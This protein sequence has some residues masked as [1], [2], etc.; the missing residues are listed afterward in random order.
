MNNFD[1]SSSGIDIDLNIF[2]DLSEAHSRWHENFVSVD[3]ENDSTYLFIMDGNLKDTVDYTVLPKQK[4]KILKAYSC[5]IDDMKYFKTLSQEDILSELFSTSNDYD[6]H[7]DVIIEKIRTVRLTEYAEICLMGYSQ[8]EVIKIL[9]N[10]KEFEKVAGISFDADK[11]KKLLYNLFF[12]AP[13]YAYITINNNDYDLDIHGDYGER[14][15]K[16]EIINDIVKQI[17]VSQPNI[18]IQVL[19]AE[20]NKLVPEDISDIKNI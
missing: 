3:D 16:Q 4:T 14:Y 7:A 11:E 13:L 5:D 6:I 8:G 2:F 15:D 9:V 1:K 17:K 10:T 12:D 20:L 19:I 18:D